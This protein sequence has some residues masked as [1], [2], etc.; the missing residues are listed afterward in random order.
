MRREFTSRLKKK[1]LNRKRWDWIRDGYDNYISAYYQTG[2]IWSDRDKCGWKFY[3][4]KEINEGKKHAFRNEGKWRHA[5]VD[6]DDVRYDRYNELPISA[7]KEEIV[8]RYEMWEASWDDY[9]WDG[10]HMIR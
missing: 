2:I 5:G 1:I 3:T 8:L 10:L 4:D 9:S 6:R 7:L